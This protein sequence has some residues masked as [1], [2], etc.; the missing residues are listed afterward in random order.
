MPVDHW[1]TSFQDE[2]IRKNWL[3]SLSGRQLNVIF[4]YSFAHKQNGQLFEFQKHDDIS[5]Q[6]QRKMLIGCSDSLFNYYLLSHFN[7]SKLES[8]VVEVARSVLAEELIANFL[9]KNNKHDKKSLVFALFHSDPELIKCVYHFDKVQKR[10][11]SSFTLQNSPRQMKTPFKNFISKEVTYRLLKEYDA[12]KDDGFETQLQGFF[13]HQNRI[14]VFIRRA[15]DKDLLFNSN[16][17]IH[18]YRPSWIILD[19]S[20]HGNQVNLCAKDF[21]ESLKIANSIVS[22]YFECECLFID[23][24][25]QNCTLLVATFL[26]SSIEGTDPNICLFE[27]KF[28]STQLKKDTYLVVVTNPVNSI[29]RELQMLKLTIEQDNSLVES[30]RIVFLEKK[31]TLFFKRNEHYTIIYYSEHILNKKEREDFKSLMKE[32]YGLT[33]LPKA[34]CC[35]YSEIS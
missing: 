23:M 4:Q 34:S 10:G 24:K 3:Y 12:E 17:I 14:Y 1:L 33:I 21:N 13:Y 29:A 19:F 11:F 15:S 7:H 25:D 6:E 32:T 35:R 20:L 16:R 28:R 8:A 9:C 22:N 2:E 27:V 26:K 30:I 18:G 5:V 31:V